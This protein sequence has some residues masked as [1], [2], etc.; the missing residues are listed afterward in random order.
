MT[1]VFLLIAAA[2]LVGA[3]GTA[4]DLTFAGHQATCGRSAAVE[5]VE[6][7]LKTCLQDATEHDGVDDVGTLGDQHTARP[8]PT[9]TDSTPNRVP[10][11]AEDMTSIKITKIAADKTTCYKTRRDGASAGGPLPTVG[12]C[13]VG[14]SAGPGTL[15]E[16]AEAEADTNAKTTTTTLQKPRM[17]PVSCS[18]EPTE[19]LVFEGHAPTCVASVAPAVDTTQN[20]AQTPESPPLVQAIHTK[21]T[22]GTGAATATVNRVPR[23]PLDNVRKRLSA[24]RR[25]HASHQ[26]PL[27]SVTIQVT[28]NQT[29]KIVGQ[30]GSTLLLKARDGFKEGVSLVRGCVGLSTAV[31]KLKL[32]SW[33]S[34][35]D[36]PDAPPPP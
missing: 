16:T 31:Y 18:G 22:A 12:T 24:L 19:N 23:A 29:A 13:R 14:R 8:L 7:T 20:A 10:R 35:R 30:G 9:P 34:R 33:T 2:A 21:T 11:T 25:L 27:P 17:C 4:P 26:D 6:K 3:S 15:A 32:V 1:L 36:V 28:I 5:S